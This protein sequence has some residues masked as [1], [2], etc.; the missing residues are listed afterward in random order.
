MADFLAARMQMA[1]SPGFH[2]T[3]ACIGKIMPFFMFVAE[4]KWI[5]TNQQV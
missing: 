4:Y 3:F 2:I 1:V 5:K